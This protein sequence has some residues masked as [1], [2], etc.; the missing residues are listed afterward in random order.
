MKTKIEE[1]I[2]NYYTMAK[3]AGTRPSG[4]FYRE[5]IR[6]LNELTNG[7]LD[8]NKYRNDFIYGDTLKACM[9][10]ET[11]AKALI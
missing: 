9:D 4:F 11:D 8:S 3:G 7:N 10:I 1:I 2:A 5:M 6:E